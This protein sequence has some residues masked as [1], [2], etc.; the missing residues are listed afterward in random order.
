MGIDSFFWSKL[1]NINQL[2]SMLDDATNL[3]DL[4]GCNV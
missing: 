2:V 3:Q 1:T 4:A